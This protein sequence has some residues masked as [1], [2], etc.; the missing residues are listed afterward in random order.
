MEH[1]GLTLD[2]A[3]IRLGLGSFLAIALGTFAIVKLGG[4]GLAGSDEAR[5]NTSALVETSR[6]IARESAKS[7]VRVE[8]HRRDHEDEELAHLF[9]S[10]I[11][12]LASQGSGVC[13]GPDVILTNYHVV[14]NA[15]EIAVKAHNQTAKARMVG[16]DVLTDLAVL[17]VTNLELAVAAWGDSSQLATGDFVWALGNPFGLEQSI[18]FGIISAINQQ[19]AGAN[20]MQE[21][22][23]TDAAVNPGGSGG[24]LVNINGEVVGINTAILGDTFRGISFAI[25]SNAARQIANELIET[26]KIE[27]GWLGLIT[28]DTLSRQGVRVRSLAGQPGSPSPAQSV[29]VE[30]G[31]V[32]VRWNNIPITSAV[33]LARLSAQTKPHTT[34]EIGIVRGRNRDELTLQTT[35]TARP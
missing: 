13:I 5:R 1:R 7:V 21:F 9:G 19:N 17:R 15:A 26:G 8:A 31:D 32:I 16:F 22:M 27:R 3:I 35:I 18:T 2:P 6:R 23:Q 28:E 24:P 11:S 29:G 30:I 10:E 14:A 34:V 4:G 33:Q 12:D 20:V 25:P